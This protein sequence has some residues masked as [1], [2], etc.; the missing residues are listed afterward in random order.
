[1]KQLNFS[2]L[3]KPKMMFGGSL[4]KSGTNPKVARPLDSRMPIH[5]V[6]RAER[7]AMRLPRNFGRVNHLVRTIAPRH[8][9]KLYEYANVGNHLHLVLKISHRG[10]WS[11]FIRDLTGAIARL[12]RVRWATRPFTRVISGWRKAFEI[13]KNYVLLNHGEAELGLS[14]ADS[15]RLKDLKKYLDPCGSLLPLPDI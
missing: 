10:T 8:G 2:K 3:T 15:R 6:L 11:G 4:I 5:L 9:V 1:M 13:A 7:S 12:T 14:R